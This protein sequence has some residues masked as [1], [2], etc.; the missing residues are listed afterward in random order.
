[1]KCPIDN[2][3]L[4]LFKKYDYTSF[5]D[6][7][8]QFRSGRSH[9]SAQVFNENNIICGEELR[10]YGFLFSLRKKSSMIYRLSE[11]GWTDF[12]NCHRVSLIKFSDIETMKNKAALI[13]TFQ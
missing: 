11:Y 8:T 1:M 9:Y 6:C 12:D 2:L 3:D 4:V 13:S 10:I 5:Y 7:L